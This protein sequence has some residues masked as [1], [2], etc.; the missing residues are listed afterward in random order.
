MQKRKLE[1]LLYKLHRGLKNISANFLP[2]H[3]QDLFVCRDAELGL[4]NLSIKSGS[5]IDFADKIQCDKKL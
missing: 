3:S 5:L 1:S 2:G 4:L